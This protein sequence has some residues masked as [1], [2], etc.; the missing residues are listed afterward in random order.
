M[1]MRILAAMFSLAFISVSW[2]AAFQPQLHRGTS[3]SD[4]ILVSACTDRCATA[5]DACRRNVDQ[6]N[7]NS[8]L[9]GRYAKCQ[10]AERQCI[11]SCP[12]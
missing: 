12:K 2:A 4:I 8:T 9:R 10:G 6:Q 5:G 1:K 7:P 3:K 11:S